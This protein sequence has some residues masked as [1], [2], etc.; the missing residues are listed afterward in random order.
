MKAPFEAIMFMKKQVVNRDLG[1]N[2]MREQKG[3]VIE[4]M[5]VILMELSRGPEMEK[6]C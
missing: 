5:K 3:Q 2:R 1:E 4:K 6:R